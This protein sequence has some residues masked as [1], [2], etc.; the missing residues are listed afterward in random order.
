M[1]S[2]KVPLLAA[3]NSSS[4]MPSML[5]NAI[6]GG[7]VASPTPTVPISSDS[8][9]VMSIPSFFSRAD[10]AAAAI[11]PAVPPPTMTI[12]RIAYSLNLF[13]LRH[14]KK[15]EHRLASPFSITAQSGF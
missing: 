10:K 7:M 13:A 2:L 5:L 9:S 3:K 14:T 11:Q 8:T 1:P 6:S 12:F 4:L 15:G